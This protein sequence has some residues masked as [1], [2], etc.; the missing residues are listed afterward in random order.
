MNLPSLENPS[1]KLIKDTGPL[2]DAP[3]QLCLFLE[4]E[5]MVG[6]H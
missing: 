5:L 2:E 6:Q 1:D 3:A 4:G